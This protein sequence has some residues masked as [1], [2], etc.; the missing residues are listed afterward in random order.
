[1]EQE[2]NYTKREFDHFFNDLFKRMDK[3][4]LVL[5]RIEGQTL[6][7]NGRVTRLEDKVADYNDIKKMAASHE[8]YKWW[9][10]GVFVAISILGTFA[11]KYIVKDEVKQALADYK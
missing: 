6:K 1:M 5:E 4:D 7:T 9:I 3:Q 10:V 2:S 8:N 11:F